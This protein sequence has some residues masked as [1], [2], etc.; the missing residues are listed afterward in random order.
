[1]SWV[2][3]ATQDAV[4]RRAAAGPAD[5]RQLPQP[6]LVIGLGDFGR[7]ISDELERR[8]AI[9]QQF[10]SAHG[11]LLAQAL[12][13]LLL[14][15]AE[16]D[17]ATA[18]A[19]QLQSDED[20]RA[21]A[22]EI[23]RR[24]ALIRAAHQPDSGV[25]R[26]T[27]IVVGACWEP[28]GAAFWRLA[29]LIRTVLTHAVDYQ[30]IGIFV[31]AQWLAPESD[32]DAREVE[33]GDALSCAVLEA[34]DQQLTVPPAYL[35]QISTVLGVQPD[36]AERL[37]V[38]DWSYL[39]DSERAD[40][41]AVAANNNSFEIEHQAVTLIETLL[42]GRFSRVLD[43]LL[44]DDYEMIR[45]RRRNAAPRQVY[46]SVG[47]ASLLVPLREIGEKVVRRV[48]AQLIRERILPTQPLTG[49]DQ[50]RVAALTD[51]IQRTLAEQQEQRWRAGLS[52]HGAYVLESGHRGRYRTQLRVSGNELRVERLRLRA[53][54]VA[55]E[56]DSLRAFEVLRRLQGE[57]DA[58]EQYLQRAV[59]AQPIDYDPIDQ[60]IGGMLAEVLQSGDS[61]LQ[62]GITVFETLLARLRDV[63]R[64]AARREQQAQ[65]LVRQRQERLSESGRAFFVDRRVI[66]DS[67]LRTRGRLLA[68]LLR[69]LLIFV[70]FY[71]FYHDALSVGVAGWPVDVVWPG[72]EIYDTGLLNPLALLL[73]AAV[74]LLFSLLA[75]LPPLAIAL[76]IAAERRR[77]CQL[78]A[79][80]LT[81]QLATERRAALDEL[82]QLLG[83]FRLP[84]L[85]DQRDRLQEYVAHVAR[86]TAAAPDQ[87][88]FANEI[89][90]VDPADVGT[91]QQIE[92]T[93]AAGR[94]LS[95]P[96]FNGWLA[97]PQHNRWLLRAAP[98]LTHGLE[99]Q[100]R[101]LVEFDA[102][103]P[104]DSYLTPD[105]AAAAL[106][107]IE[108]AAA[109][110]AAVAP[111]LL[112]LEDEAAHQLHELTFFAAANA[113]QPAGGALQE[114]QRGAQR[115]GWLD[116]YRITF[117]KVVGGITTDNFGRM[118]QLR[119]RSKLS[120]GGVSGLDAATA[121]QEQR[122]REALRLAQLLNSLTLQQPDGV[123]RRGFALAANSLE[124]LLQRPGAWQAAEIAEAAA[125][126]DRLRETQL[127]P[128][129][130]RRRL[131]DWYTEFDRWLQ[132]FAL[133]P[134]TPQVGTPYDPLQ[135]GTAV[136]AAD[137]NVADGVIVAR[138]RRGYRQPG[139]LLVE[140][141]VSV[142]R[143]KG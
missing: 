8:T 111:S 99:R 108:P 30:L 100:V 105:V 110:W 67:A 89:W 107:R 74:A 57:A 65:A 26:P 47:F 7:R 58:G 56:D 69:S 34:G 37:L 20:L 87:P 25:V 121:P 33:L 94:A 46:L 134:L 31:T 138:I 61:G 18:A 93:D 42:Y 45:R 60:R 12:P 38:Y 113:D 52:E 92:A 142:N 140:P 120:A 55:G 101:R 22:R 131:D 32:D 53:D 72:L 95:G 98:E 139:Q 119:L 117:I 64:E 28:A 135:H 3:T 129:P 73:L 29:A 133:E 44:L 4:V 43:Q 104:V 75:F 24:F 106:R 14:P 96:L 114:L 109:P 66:L 86:Q 143:Y 39:L 91:L 97:D 136:E 130:L 48:S 68:V 84:L 5:S 10:R 70:L 122:R 76:H 11:G 103:R 78:L 80:R 85:H 116:R 49:T 41:S 40:G 9:A 79:A 6:A 126:L 118:A 19:W 23:S 62:R 90:V 63:L 21:A 15:G 54:N 137:A 77:V 2:Q 16:V 1:M 81:L 141:L 102:L 115:L 35:Q 13:L 112:P 71:Q 128:R 59:P 88:P 36:D 125:E 124:R 83:D 132:H 82:V 51:E 17:A 27:I 123:L 127:L 50:L